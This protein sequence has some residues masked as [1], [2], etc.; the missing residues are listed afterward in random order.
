MRMLSL[1]LAAIMAALILSIPV[2]L[3]QAPVAADSQIDLRGFVFAAVS[4]PVQKQ[5]TVAL[6]HAYVTL[7]DATNPSKPLA[8]NR[9]DL[10]GHFTLKVDR[11]AG[12]TGPAVAPTRVFVL[13]VKAEGFQST[14]LDKRII[15]SQ[16]LGHVLVR[17]AFNE[18]SAAAFGSLTLHD[19]S[20]ARGFEPLFGVNAFATIEA[21]TARGAFYKGYLNNSGVYI[22]PNAPTDEEF[23]LL[24]RIEKETLERRI[25]K[26]AMPLPGRGYHFTFQF[27]N[28]AP[29]VR[30]VSATMNDRPLQI[31]APGSTVKLRAVT[32]DADGDRL[33]YRWLTP[34][35]TVGSAPS[36][37]AELDWK[38]PSQNGEYVIRVLAS[39]GRGGY[40]AG[41]MALS[42]NSSVS[43]SGTVVD[44]NGKAVAG[45]LFEVNGRVTNASAAGKVSISVP[46]QDKYVVNIRQGGPPIPGQ[47]NFGTASYIYAGGI[48]GE[49][50]R[51]R[52]ARVAS[53]DPTAPIT[54]QHERSRTDCEAAQPR[55]SRIDWSGLIGNPGLFNLQDGRGRSMT[56]AEFAA[57]DAAGVAQIARLL[58][59]YD[60]KLARSFFDSPAFQSPKSSLAERIGHGRGTITFDDDP[61]SR[62]FVFDLKLL[63]DASR[64]DPEP[65]A[66]TPLPCRNGIKVEFPADALESTMTKK[67]PTGPVQVVVS[68]VDLND[69]SHM[70]GDFTAALAD[71]KLGSMESF[72]AGSIE[73]WSGT[74]RYNL[75]E[76][77]SATITIPVDATQLTGKPSLPATIPLLYY[78][79]A[80]GIWKQDGEA[81]LN[82]SGASSAYVATAKHFSTLNGDIL[83]SGE[84]CLAVEIDPASSFIYPLHV[85]VNLQPSK[86]NPT[87]VQ[88]RDLVINS[89]GE[90]S[91]IYNLPFKQYVTLTPIAQGALPDGSTGNV[92]GGIFAVNTGGPQNSPTAPPTPNADGTYYKEVNGQ[93]VGPCA[94]RVVL[95]NLNVATLSQPQAPLEFLQGL[96]FQASN[97]TEFDASD[98][99][100][101]AKIVQGA[102]DYYKVAD[103][104]SHRP[105]LQQFKDFNHFGQ[106]TGPTEAEY[107]AT[108]ANG[109]DLGFGREMHCRKNAAPDGKFDYACYVSNY[110]QPP[111]QVS[112]QQAADDAGSHINQPTDATVTM[113]YSRVE[114]APGDPTEFPDSNRAV[115]FYAYNTNTGVQVFQAD[116]DGHGARPLPNLC[117][118]CH[119]GKSADV[120]SDPAN[121]QSPKVPAFSTRADVLNGN[122]KF[123]PFDL[124]F[125][126]FPTSDH[127]ED[128]FRHLNIDIVKQVEA[129]ISSG[130][131]GE[132]IDAWYPGGAGTQHDAVVITG[133]DTGG[134]A[135]PNNKDNLMYR[136][137]F[138]RA[139]RTCHVA[140][141]YTAPAFRTVGDFTAAI[142]TV[143]NRVCHDKVMPHAQR[144]NIIFW[145]SLNPSMAGYT[146]I[147]GEAQ[148]PL[149]QTDKSLQCG[150]FNQDAGDVKSFF[151]GT[152][153]PILH[154][155]GCANSSCH[156]NAGNAN[157][158]IGNVADTYNS[159]L[160]A[161][162]KS[163]SGHYIA[164]NDLA[165][166]VLYQRLLNNPPPRMP[167]GGSDLTQADTNGDG[168]PDANEVQSWITTYGAVGP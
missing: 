61:Q 103:P 26:G 55:G 140:Q 102:T 76:G 31:A 138:A 85:E 11:S 135:D 163:G 24:A 123:L 16:D 87:V 32:F 22:V 161:V 59:R 19:G 2:L 1:V 96:Y 101:A 139:C 46:V 84:S 128:S 48:K 27:A 13:C 36:S 73:V 122:S 132:L 74:E 158:S 20:L 107:S 94:A 43:F 144:T 141:P 157:F 130:A 168:S 17:P 70:P 127:Q 9:S 108:Y 4:D 155:A 164:P 86:P 150:L 149:W 118:V 69:P 126:K 47:S 109:G 60:P 120:L 40:A 89:S 156:A 50:W 98:P 29:K 167:L 104:R 125:Y 124:H 112:D 117:I 54:L 116:L 42:V 49:Q 90:H 75:K 121:S 63:G 100:T 82:G 91:V 68:A 18:K 33:E 72:G 44:Q 110:D 145:N 160:S 7:A 99:T 80:N 51:L 151:E 52:P 153:D 81:S 106:P 105:N 77:A 146:E 41:H 38:V 154:T 10:S 83:K 88:V 34:D 39:D 6:P 137:V 78:D 25:P 148:G 62:A 3:A 45:A 93:P 97:I 66:A 92:P 95:T 56:L 21:R 53:F 142:Q 147:F 114:S 23:V 165:G 57:S 8:A 136:N 28:N 131:I 152:V 58:S 162:P 67:S 113:E 133:W 134:A 79:E 119:G 71:D 5:V 129:Q 12:A 65:F 159:L 35:L 37:S 115:K 111:H 166:S 14:C 64:D 143:Q 30:L 15:Q